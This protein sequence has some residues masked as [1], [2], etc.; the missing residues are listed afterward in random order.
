MGDKKLYKV[1]AE[2]RKARFNYTIEN[3]LECGI[4]LLGTEVKSMREGKFS[5]KDSYIKLKNGQLFLVGLHIT[6]YEHGTHENHE[7][8][9]VR[10]LLAHKTEIKKLKRKVEERGYTLIPLKF[11][12]KGSFIK[13][14][15][16]ICQGKKAHD[17]RNAIKERDQKKA[18]ARELKN[19][20]A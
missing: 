18:M 6:P 8:E 7:P 16:G 15:M 4:E 3:N 5:F 14:D 1:L 2:N 13:I 12:L 9:R 11:Y 10:R 17:K 20:K 19:S